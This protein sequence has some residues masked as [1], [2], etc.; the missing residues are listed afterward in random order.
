MDFPQS[1]RDCS[2][3]LQMHTH[4]IYSTR[5]LAIAKLLVENTGDWQNVHHFDVFI[6]R[7]IV[8]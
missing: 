4:I 3:L 5:K 8:Q 2:T 7:H 1:V 6:D